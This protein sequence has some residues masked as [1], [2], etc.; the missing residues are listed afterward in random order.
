MTIFSKLKDT[1]F[2][3]H[4]NKK[5]NLKR[6]LSFI[7]GV[8]FVAIAYNVFISPN[9]MVPG[10]VSGIAIVLNNLFGLDN[11]LVILIINI[12]LV[13]TSFILLG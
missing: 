13:I 11:S 4:L 7:L 2:V 9:K 5:A 3:E 1:K 8:F 10:G 12:F 6:Y